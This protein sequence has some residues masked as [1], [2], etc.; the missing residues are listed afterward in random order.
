MSDQQ[1]SSGQY[2]GANIKILEG[3]EA[4]RMRPG[5]Y[6]GDT[7]ERGLHH[8]VYEVVDNSVDEA[9]AGHCDRVDVHIHVD[10]SISVEDNGRG[11]PTDIHPTEGVPTPQV[12]LTKLH[13]GGKFDSDSYKVSGGLHGVGVSCVNALSAHLRV[14][15][16]QKG[17]YW[18]QDYERGV[19]ANEF[20]VQGNTHK[21]G[22][23]ITFL[24]DD[25]IFE[26]TEYKYEILAGRLR[27]LAFLNRGVRI[28]LTD[29]RVEDKAAEFFYEGGI[30]SF[31][32]HLVEKKTPLHPDPVY[33]EGEKDG[34][35]CEIAMQWSTAYNETLLSF[36]N[37]INTREGGTHLSGFRG[38]LTR[39]LNG[40][41]SKAGLLKKLKENL[42]GEDLREGLTAII[43]VKIPEPQFEGQ[44][45]TKLGNSNVRG[46]VESIVNEQLG[47][48]LEMNPAVGKTVMEKAVE[49]Q[50][51]RDAARKARDLARRKT[52]M[53]GGG[54]PGKLADCQEKDPTQCE[55]YLVEGD[56]A[57]GSAKS[58]RDRKFQAILPLRGKILNVEKARFDR[59]LGNEEI[60]TMITALGAGIGP[61]EFDLEKLRYHRVIIMTDADVDGAHIRTLLLTFFF[62]QMPELVE[63]GHLYIAQPPLYK[64]KKGKKIEYLKDDP[65]LTSYLFDLGARS[66]T[67]DAHGR[68]SQIEGDEFVAMLDAIREFKA[69]LDRV[70]RMQDRRVLHAFVEAFQA[71]P[72]AM[73]DRASMEAVRDAMKARL[74]SLYRPE[75]LRLTQL[76]LVHEDD[77]D[78]WEIL[79]RTRDGGVDRFTELKFEFVESPEFQRLRKLWRTALEFGAPGY[80]VHR[81]QGEP[82]EFR[83][84]LELYDHVDGASRKGFDIQRYKGLGEMNPDQL[85]ETTMDPEVRTL[86]QVRVNDLI[87]AGDIFTTLMGDAVEPRRQFIEDNAL[88]VR[89]LDV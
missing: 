73:R 48:F 39:T 81:K 76:D 3:L 6:I 31:V 18:A 60:V 64:V 57:G 8:L 24:P 43:S 28:C 53:D 13:A 51:A 68:E 25:T 71:E 65:A 34:V 77:Y 40:W 16:F 49:A 80:T 41:G 4:V 7:F 21:R 29:E 5:M 1:S 79:A 86:I 15:V 69:L 67:V 46:I 58:A 83:T 88:N 63:S 20:L 47:Y 87:E 14:E 61:G 26:T 17:K 27:E 66:L 36:A 84:E 10:G 62:R 85:W 52:V 54:L 45:K 50:R 72:S 82:L 23:K 33:L 70:T 30:V 74:E 2:T 59:M 12:V 78:A 32:Q 19:P 55:L 75:D 9:L 37:N 42:S 22:T 89:N 35:H 38:A 56:S 11:I 44:T